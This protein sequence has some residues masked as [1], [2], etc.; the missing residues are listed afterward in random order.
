M[1]LIAL[2]L[3]L[4]S[5]S[6]CTAPPKEDM[7]LNLRVLR[8][9]DSCHQAIAGSDHFTTYHCDVRDEHKIVYECEVTNVGDT[10]EITVPYY[11]N[12][13]HQLPHRK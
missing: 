2:A 13:N 6:C 11:Y 3:I 9:K 7:N 4:C 8:C 10:N 1:R 12:Y 5:G